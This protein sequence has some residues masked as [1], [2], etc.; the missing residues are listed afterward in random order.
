MLFIHGAASSADFWHAQIEAFPDALY[1]NL[2]GH[3]AGARP[4]LGEA[5]PQS[6][7]IETGLELYADYVESVIAQRKLIDIILVG[8]SMGAAVALTLALRH[9]RWLRGL[10]LTGT[11]ARLEVSSELLELLGTDYTAAVDMIVAS[12]FAGSTGNSTYAQRVLREGTRRKLLRLPPYVAL[13]DYVACAGFDIR[14]NLGRVRVP[15]L[16]VVG[17]E[18]RMTPPHLSEELYAGLSNSVLHVVEGAGHML[19]VEK[20]GEYNGIV[21]RFSQGLAQD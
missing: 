17:A 15:A 1:L 19:P 4:Y 12:S 20:P 9:P 7:Y 11:G 8:H 21:S 16:V 2:P 18:D 6:R 13:G 5:N 14:A 3:G 10:V